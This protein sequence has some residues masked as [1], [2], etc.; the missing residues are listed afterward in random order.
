VANV[1]DHGLMFHH[2]VWIGRGYSEMPVMVTTGFCRKAVLSSLSAPGGTMRVTSAKS[3][4][5]EIRLPD[6]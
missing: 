2:R 4:M 3:R 6:L 1:V 5:R